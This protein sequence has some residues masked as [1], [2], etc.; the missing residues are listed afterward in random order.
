M[1][2]PLVKCDD[3]FLLRI[4]GGSEGATLLKTSMSEKETVLMDLPTVLVPA[5]ELDQYSAKD[6]QS[7]ERQSRGDQSGERQLGEEQSGKRQL[8]EEQSGERE[9]RSGERHLGEKQSEER[10]ERTG[11]RQLGEDEEGKRYDQ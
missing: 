5:S 6:G 3:G 10:E 11:E 2:L 1:K 8:G 9:N 7:R 4:D